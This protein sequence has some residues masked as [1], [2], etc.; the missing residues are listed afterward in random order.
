[1]PEKIVFVEMKEKWEKDYVLQNME[2]TGPIIFEEG[3]LQELGTRHQDVTLLSTF[4][5]SRLTRKDFGQFPHL[6]FVTTR[7]T[8]FDHI[9]IEAA[10]SRGIS[11]ANVP[12]YGENTVA[13]H[14]FA[15]IL[16]LSRNL[17]KA[18]FKTKDGDFSLKGL[19]GFDLKGKTLGVIGTGHIGLHVI[20]MARGFGLKVL[21]YD[22]RK[23]HFLSEVMGFDY[24]PFEDL[25]AQSDVISLHVPLIPSTHHLINLG[26]I[27][28]IKRGAVLINTARGGLVQTA[29]V[30]KALDEEILA[31]AGLDVLEGEEL[32]LE[33]KRL[34]ESTEN[35]EA[36]EKLQL[37]LKNHILLHR[38]NVIYTPHM[39]FYSKEAV[40]RILDTTISNIRSFLAG[41]P[42]N[43][44]N[45][46]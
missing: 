31:G 16:S 5:N 23:N 18:Y 34:L 30:V 33:E 2:G 13:E 28:K 42:E 32:I 7:S 21:A 9:D 46:K 19:M 17:R 25:L 26:N 22:G 44:V 36:W 29:A 8:G 45:L 6:R 40:I 24:V 10:K 4:I 14:T 35:K 3:Q 41:N 37:T 15:L 39:A 11:V 20:H 12:T 1:M 38:D 43:V 27:S